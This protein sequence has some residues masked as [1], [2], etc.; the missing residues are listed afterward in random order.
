[1]KIKVT[2]QE[3]TAEYSSDADITNLAQI[4]QKLCSLFLISNFYAYSLFLSSGQIIDNLNL[5]ED[6]SEI[7]IKHLTKLGPTPSFGGST[8][9]PQPTQPIGINSNN[10][11]NSNNTLSSSPS[12]NVAANSIN[13]TITVAQNIS[14][15]TLLNNLK[16]NVLKKKAFFDL[17]DLKEE[18]L[19]RKFV[20]K[21]GIDSIISQIKD[22][23]GNTLSYA[24]SALQ[25]IVSYEFGLTSIQLSN[26]IELTKEILPM[27]ENSNPSISKTSLSLLCLFLSKSSHSVEIYKQIFKNNN[28]GNNNNNNDKLYNKILVQ[29]LGSSSTVDIQLNSLTLINNIINK[30]LQVDGELEFNKLLSELDSYEINP[31]LKKLVEGI[32]APELKRQLYIYQRHRFQVITNRKN[33]VFNK[34]SPEHDALLMKLWNLTFPSVKL[35]SR[36]SEQWK[37]MGFQGTDPCTDFRGMGIFG[38]DNLVYF[39]EH[40]GDKFRKIVNSQVDRKDREYPTA[41]AGIVITFEL[42]NTIFKMGDK[43]NPNLPID[44]IPLFPLFFSH[45]NAFEEVYC[46]TFQILDSTWDDMNGTYMYFQKI[47]SSVKNL[48]ISALESKPTTLEAFEWKCPKNNLK[49]NGLVFNDQQQSN[50]PHQTDDIKGLCQQVNK[51]VL[52]FIKNQ[53]TQYLSE[54]FQFK[55]HKPIKSKSSIVLNYINIKLDTNNSNLSGSSNEIY[56]QYC[57][58]PSLDVSPVD[59]KSFLASTNYNTIKVLDLNFISESTSNSKKKDKSTNAN[60]HFTISIKDEQFQQILQQPIN[61]GNNF[62]DLNIINKDNS[63][64]NNNSNSSTP[65]TTSTPTSLTTSPIMIPQSSNSISNQPPLS[66]SLLSMSGGML[67]PSSPTSNSSHASSNIFELV[68]NN[69]EDL[70]NF[71]DS[72]RLLS[73]QDIKSPEGSEDYQ[74]LLNLNT[75]LK[76]LDL[77]GIDIPLQTPPIPLLPENYEFRNI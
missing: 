61:G 67:P 77:E 75:S 56:I 11:I 4:T 32:I 37:Q 49:Q 39:A 14:I 2:F 70:C 73:G 74:S 58:L 72:I 66:P 64:S 54:G 63:N 9:M 3:R 21:N 1:M 23:T 65:N 62:N 51:E 34:E 6:G 40:Y 68:S 28:N 10:N 57:L 71:W 36:V 41:T 44:E 16:D 12:T 26:S 15:D 59:S 7:I 24:L 46:T 27:I 35:E 47:I 76:L 31:K 33:V 43:V 17:K 52:E 25:T 30:T 48:I 45:P 8:G 5:I 69:R 20:E 42:Y 60:F 55:L 19:I 22:L 53:K 38:L 50:K 29:L 13:N 18:I